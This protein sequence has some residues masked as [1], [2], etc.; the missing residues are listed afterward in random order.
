MHAARAM[1]AKVTAT[2]GGQIN[3]VY[4]GAV[5]ATQRRLIY[6]RAS[7]GRRAINQRW[8]MGP[9]MLYVLGERLGL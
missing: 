1:A 3:P 5:Y 8:A 2:L 7:G 9:F 4:M 6:G